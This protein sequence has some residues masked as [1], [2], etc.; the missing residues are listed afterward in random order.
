MKRL[1]VLAILCIAVGCGK[2]KPAENK[3]II[4]NYR[5]LDGTRSQATIEHPGEKNEIFELKSE[6]G[7]KIQLDLKSD[8]K[9]SKIYERNGIS[10]EMKADSLIIKQDGNVI[11]LS[12]IK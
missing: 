12:E 6:N 10:A 4:K 3:A 9:N 11:P 8:L 7:K 1:G 2:D 5:A